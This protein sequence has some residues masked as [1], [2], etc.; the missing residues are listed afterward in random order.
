MRLEEEISKLSD[1]DI[2]L[3]RQISEES[4]VTLPKIVTCFARLFISEKR[5]KE[6]GRLHSD[7]KIEFFYKSIMIFFGVLAVLTFFVETF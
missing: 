3:S 4:P 7:G 6:N 2:R 5:F 1:V